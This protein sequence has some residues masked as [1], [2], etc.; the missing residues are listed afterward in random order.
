MKNS[1][2]NAVSTLVLSSVI[3]GGAT[4]AGAFN[5]ASPYAD[6]AQMKENEILHVPTGTKVSKDQLIETVASSRVI[7]I[8]E[9]E[10]NNTA[11]HL[12]QLEILRALN[13]KFPGKIAV[14]MEMFRRDAQDSLNKWSGGELSQDKFLGIFCANWGAWFESYKPVFD[15]MHEQSIP[16]IGLKSAKETETAFKKGK[17]H[18]DRPDIPEV[19][20]DDVHYKTYQMA[21]FDLLRKMAE[22][23]G[24]GGHIPDP[25]KTYRMMVLWDEVMAQ[26]AAQFLDD[27]ANTD[28]K[29]VVIAGTGHLQYGFGIPNRTFRRHPE[30]YSII[31][32]T[33]Y[34]G[35]EKTESIP[36]LV[37]K[38]ISI[39]LP[40]S[41]F[42]WKIPMALAE[43]GVCV[44]EPAP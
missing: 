8:G 37:E 13:E 10:H 27:P 12:V 26:T 38:N 9:P 14:G 39:P 18:A 7:Y 23:Q 2:K 40:R 44:K 3:A 15:Y 30:A 28:K 24:D 20:M 31:L 17:T 36:S 25:V 34:D 4:L 19:N 35:T 42:A 16:L 22:E 11:A 21:T 1:L 29:L 43:P 5:A 33:T 6:P 32:P 41:H